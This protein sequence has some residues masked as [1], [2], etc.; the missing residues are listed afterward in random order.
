MGKSASIWVKNGQKRGKTVNFANN[1]TFFGKKCSEG[2]KSKFSAGSP[3][4]W[5]TPLH[6]APLHT[7][8]EIATTTST[9]PPQRYGGLSIQAVSEGADTLELVA[10][11]LDA[12]A[13]TLAAAAEEVR[14]T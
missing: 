6:T 2:G 10:R 1:W 4:T 14:A 5:C 11:E 8:V 3:V 13:K 9:L 7:T 12:A